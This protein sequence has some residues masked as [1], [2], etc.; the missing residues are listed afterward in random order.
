MSATRH[1]DRIIA[2]IDSCLEEYEQRTRT[3]GAR[4]STEPPRRAQARP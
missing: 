2:L 3:T 1:C 4:S